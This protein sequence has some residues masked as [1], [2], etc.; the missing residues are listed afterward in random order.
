MGDGRGLDGGL[1]REWEGG[2][3]LRGDWLLRGSKDGVYEWDMSR[4]EPLVEVRL[5][6]IRHILLDGVGLSYST[7]CMA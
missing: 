3:V 1:W 6:R 5:A 7:A 2:R 4:L